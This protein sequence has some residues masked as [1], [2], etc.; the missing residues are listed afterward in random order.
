MSKQKRFEK[1]IVVIGARGFKGQSLLR[2]L[3]ND[4][5]YKKVVAI[6]HKKPELPLKKTRFYKLDLT[7]TLADVTLAKILSKER[8]DTL[9]HAALPITP[10]Q[11]ELL[12]HEVVAIGTLYI[13]NACSAAQV[14]KLVLLSTADVYGAFATNPNYLT[15]EMKPMGH[16]QSNFLKDKIDA[17]KQVLTYQKKYPD[18]TVTILRPCTIIGPTIDSYKT[19]YLSRT[20]VPTML[21]FDPLVQFVH[22]EDLL[23]ATKRLIDEDHPGVFNLAGDGVLPLSR[24]I[25]LSGRINVKLGQM[26]FKLLTQILWMADLAPVP[27]ALLNFLRYLCVVDNTKIKQTLKFQLRYTSKEALLSFIGTDRLRKMNL[28]EA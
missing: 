18:N 7:E 1:S 20:V 21:G 11:N 9:I 13:I 4:H 15:E 26:G 6:D 27:A 3:E 12:S 25:C 10:S 2:I 22:E 23:T 28:V 16:L 24:A 14:R 17:E 8:C 5:K 19:R